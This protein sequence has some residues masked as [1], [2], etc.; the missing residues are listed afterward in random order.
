M[1]P[2]RRFLPALALVPGLVLLPAGPASADEGGSGGEDNTAVAINTE[3]GASVFRLAFSVRRVADGLVDETNE[4][5]AL[6]SC[7]DCQTIA[8]AFQVVLAFGDVDVVVPENRA[9]AYNDRCTECV[10]YASATQLVLGFDGPVRLTAEGWQRLMTLRQALRTLEERAPTLTLAELNAEVQSAKAELI[11]ILEDELVEVPA[12]PV[13][14]PDQSDAAA[15]TT[16]TS[17]PDPTGTTSTSTANSSTTS[18]ST[19][20]STSPSTTSSSSTTTTTTEPSSTTTS[21]TTAGNG[22]GAG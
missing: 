10:T 22:T 19:T 18:T 13:D 20:T 4:A 15:S 9:V 11:S 8:L 14:A 17:L 16:T 12:L 6:A 3:D 7:T 21:T 5:Y 1:K 2:L